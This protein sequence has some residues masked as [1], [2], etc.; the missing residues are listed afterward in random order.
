MEVAWKLLGEYFFV[1]GL[2]LF[3]VGVTQIFNNS[4]G[5][6]IAG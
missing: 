6:A 4:F 3:I 2:S 1:A 5:I